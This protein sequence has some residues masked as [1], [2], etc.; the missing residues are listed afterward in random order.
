MRTRGRQR[1]V[2]RIFA[3]QFNGDQPRFVSGTVD[4]TVLIVTFSRA[5]TVPSSSHGFTAHID[6]VSQTPTYSSGSPS[7]IITFGLSPAAGNGQTTQFG[8][9]PSFTDPAFRPLGAPP[10]SDI[11]SLVLGSLTNNTSSSALGI[12]EL[13]SGTTTTISLPTRVSGDRLLLITNQFVSGTAS[14][15]AGW[16]SLFGTGRIGVYEKTSDGSEAAPA[17]PNTE[18]SGRVV[19]R[20]IAV[21]NTSGREDFDQTDYQAD[22]VAVSAPSSTSGG[23]GR[24][25]ITVGLGLDDS[26]IAINE[27]TGL[28]MPSAQTHGTLVLSH[29][30]TRGVVLRHGY[31]TVGAGGTGVKDVIGNNPQATGIS[32]A[33]FNVIYAP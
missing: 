28:F 22:V 8:Y 21:K 12:R 24:L 11:A 7:T 16:T 6:G 29:D 27:L 20:V 23:A 9:T 26:D 10:E 5:V 15:P 17:W 30:G 13:S 4:G 32:M 3:G 18:T 1:Q 19:W 33:A 2:G 14:T 31:Q 25:L